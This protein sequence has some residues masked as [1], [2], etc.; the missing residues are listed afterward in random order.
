M[1]VD[2]EARK[3][4]LWNQIYDLDQFFIAHKHEYSP[5]WWDAWYREMKYD[6]LE[7]ELKSLKEGK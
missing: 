6:E 5:A 4:E 7:A 1:S 3:E 2:K